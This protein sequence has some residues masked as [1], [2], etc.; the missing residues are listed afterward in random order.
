[1]GTR[2]GLVACVCGIIHLT[3]CVCRK[4]L[5]ACNTTNFRLRAPSVFSCYV[6]AGCRATTRAHCRPI[7]VRIPSRPANWNGLLPTTAAVPSSD[8]TSGS[9]QAHDTATAT[10]QPTFCIKLSH[11]N[12]F[13][14]KRKGN[15]IFCQ[16]RWENLVNGS[17]LFSVDLILWLPLFF[18]WLWQ[19]IPVSVHS[20]MSLPIF[21][22][23]SSSFLQAQSSP[24]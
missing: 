4:R 7:P 24:V 22:V 9:A 11:D 15:S 3:V 6:Y 13:D 14:Y 8:K 20:Q 23:V 10:H 1:M 16:S 17:T 18:V 12:T 21:E 19:L 5:R 2:N